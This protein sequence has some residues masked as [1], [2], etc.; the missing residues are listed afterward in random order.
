MP[1]A[2]KLTPLTK[3]HRETSHSSLA[4]GALGRFLNHFFEHF[5]ELGFGIV[6]GLNARRHQSLAKWTSIAPTRPEDGVCR[7]GLGL[8]QGCW[9]G[10]VECLRIR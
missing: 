3:T 4:H 8:A 1:P 2:V 5:I 6:W 7:V 10:K 9:M